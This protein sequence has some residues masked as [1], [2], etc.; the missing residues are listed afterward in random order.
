MIKRGFHF[1]RKVFYDKL[2]RTSAWLFAGFF[3]SS[4][5][6]YAFQ[7]AMGRLL[8]PEEFG[9]MNALLGVFVILSVPVVTLLMILSKKTA[10]Y[11]AKK[12]LSQVKGLFTLA[13]KFVSKFGLIGFVLFMAVSGYL[14]DYLH[15]PNVVPVFIL[16][17]CL[18]TAVAL[19]VNTAILQGLQDYFWYGINQGLLGPLK[20]LFCV[21][22]VFYGLGVN[23]AMAGVLATNVVLWFIAFMP[24]R[25][26]LQGADNPSSVEP[27]SWKHSLP[28]LITN[29]AFSIMTQIDIV[30]VNRYFSAQEA[31]VYAAAAV[32]GRTV[33]YIPGT[34]VQA[35]YPMV[36]EQHTLNGDTRSLLLKSL[37]LT[38]SLSGAGALIFFVAPDLILTTLFG[39]RYAGGEVLLKYFGLAML[40]VALMMLMSGYLLARGESKFPYFMLLAA[41]AE[42]VLISMCHDSLYWVIGVMGGLSAILVALGVMRIWTI[43]SSWKH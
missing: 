38:L 33:M 15:A 30:L 13:N 31:A 21:L 42:F 6:N 41:V 20:F 26:H 18:L 34:I 37:L 22:L 24:L 43:T 8:S 35:M 14:A 10:E 27:L 16:G 23:G 29:L 40:P 19:P 3:I 2:V 28:V 1:S 12:N 11:R 17:L 5:F 9:F 4:L 39:A 36:S 25:R 32:L 7:I